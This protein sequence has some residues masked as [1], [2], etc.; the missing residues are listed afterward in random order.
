M[1][2]S[3]DFPRFQFYYLGIINQENPRLM[4][5]HGLPATGLWIITTH[6]LGK[7]WVRNDDLGV[8]KV[9]PFRYL[10]LLLARSTILW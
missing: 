2:F 6:M 9:G 10:G 8:Y 4:E 3:S 7:P 1:M 5:S